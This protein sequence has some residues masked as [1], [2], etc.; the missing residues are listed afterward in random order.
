MDAYLQELRKKCLIGLVGGSDIVKIAEQIGG[1]QAIAKYDYVFAEN[2]L[3]AYKD[4]KQFFEENIQKHVGEDNLQTFINYCL[5]YLSEITL[6][7]KR[8]VLLF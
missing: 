4:G 3:V 6:P 7:F 8:F 2:G 1:T 5:K